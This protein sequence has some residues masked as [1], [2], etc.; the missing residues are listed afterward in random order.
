MSNEKITPAIQL[1]V[2]ILFQC[3]SGCAGKII[4]E[5]RRAGFEVSALESFSLERANAEEFLE[6]YK[7]VLQEYKGRVD[8][9]NSTS[10]C[11]AGQSRKNRFTPVFRYMHTFIVGT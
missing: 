9:S 8:D 11:I 6:I 5:I 7:G 4:S 3:L 1:P 10:I 2:H